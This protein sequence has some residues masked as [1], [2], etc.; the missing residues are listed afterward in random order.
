ML[1]SAGVT[2]SRKNLLNGPE[3]VILETA[4]DIVLHRTLFVD[5]FPGPVGLTSMVHMAWDVA[6]AKLSESGYFPP[7]PQSIMLVC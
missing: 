1:D 4:K 7:S 3:R 2:S 6:Q 5:P